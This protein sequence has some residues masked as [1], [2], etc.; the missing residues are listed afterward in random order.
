MIHFQDIQFRYEGTISSE[1]GVKDINLIVHTGECVLLCGRSGCGKTT[2]TK[3]INGL[4]PNYFPG[5]LSG[6]V[7]ID[8]E[9]ILGMPMYYLATK[10][11]SV[12]QNPRTQFFNVDVDSEIA[13]GIE[14]IAVPPD[15]LHQRLEYTLDSLKIRKL[16]G[17][18]IFELSGGEKQKI[19][20]ASVYAMNPDIFLLD[21]PSSNLDGDSIRDLKNYLRI[22][23]QQGKTILI[24]EHR[25]YYLLDIADRIVYLADGKIEKIYAAFIVVLECGMAL[26]IPIGG[27]LFLNGSITAS[28]F[29]LFAYIG[30][31]YLSELLPLQQLSMELAQ[32]LNGVK[33]AKQILDLPIFDSV[34]DFPKSHDVTLKAVRFSYDGKTDVLTDCDLHVAEGEKVAIVGASGAGKTTVIEL[35]SRFYDVT[36]GEVLI[37]GQNI[38]DI[39]YEKL[40]NNISIVFQKTFLTRDSVLEN[41]RM[42]SNATLEEV[43]A[44]AKEAQIDD[45]IMSLPDGYDTKVGSFGSRFSGGEKQRIAIARA[46][47]KN[48]PILILD[49]ATSAAD[50]ENQVEIDMAISNLCK[51]KTVLIVAHRLGAIKMCD[52]VAVVENHTITA[53]GTHEEVLEENR[54]YQKAWERYHAAREVSYSMKG[55]ISYESK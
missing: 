38:K 1:I 41:I 6:N 30:S 32:S 20:F 51:G 45:F 26:I 23:K 35:I 25:L 15:E 53:F 16:Q 31:L 24:A 18:N 8:D 14:N 3:L 17:K 49:E 11:G 37:G 13:F 22:L 46:I 10:V 27:R 43:R 5:E 4:I 34:G 2:L 9:N 55:V 40:L 12:F 21:E 36:D 28:I 52:K 54:Y 33:K 39:A 7:Q 42:G 48:A 47:L 44:A 19:A 50:P 29:L